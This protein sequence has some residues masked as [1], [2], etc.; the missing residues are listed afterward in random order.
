MITGTHMLIFVWFISYMDQC[1]IDH[2]DHIQNLGGG[3]YNPQLEM[4]VTPGLSHV[5]QPE[6]Q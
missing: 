4:K 6:M 3:E 5:S 1:A 2:V